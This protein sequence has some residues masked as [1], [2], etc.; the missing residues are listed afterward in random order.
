MT[1]AI[2]TVYGQCPKKE[3]LVLHGEPLV[4]GSNGDVFTPCV[5][6]RSL[7]VTTNP[8]CIVQSQTFPLH[9]DTGKIDAHLSSSDLYPAQPDQVKR[10]IPTSQF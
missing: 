4:C 8:D 9:N 3:C 10:E 1:R 5:I 7:A 6:L 2:G